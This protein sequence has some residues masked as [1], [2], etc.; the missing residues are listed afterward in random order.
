MSHKVYPSWRYHPEHEA[1]IVASEEAEKALGAG[2]VHSPAD[3]KP[4]EPVKKAKAKPS[5][6]MKESEGDR[7]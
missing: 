6:E 5:K 3:I 7:A 4:V 2:W 1:R